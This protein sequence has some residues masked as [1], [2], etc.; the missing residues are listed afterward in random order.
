MFQN[1]RENRDTSPVIV[2]EIFTYLNII[3][4]IEK[5]VIVFDNK[6]S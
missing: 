3:V 2:S 6:K 1:R 4:L 5:N